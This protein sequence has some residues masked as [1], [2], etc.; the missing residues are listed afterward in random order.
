MQKKP[1]GADLN[2]YDGEW[3]LPFGLL[4]LSTLYGS[5]EWTKMVLIIMFLIS[6]V[7]IMFEHR[8]AFGRKEV[9][10]RMLY[11]IGAFIAS[12]FV[13]V[14]MPIYMAVSYAVFASKLKKDKEEQL[15]AI[16]KKTYTRMF[17]ILAFAV[18]IHYAQGMML[19]D[20]IAA[21][22]QKE[23]AQPSQAVIGRP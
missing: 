19:A 16:K 7:H 22:I 23:Q 8:V 10:T 14:L 3:V 17:F 18:F 21:G 12:I 9:S 6:C 13:A 2:F 5:I 11:N 15:L 4:S 20:N 1:F